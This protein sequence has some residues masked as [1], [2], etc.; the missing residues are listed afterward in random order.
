MVDSIQKL[1]KDTDAAYCPSLIIIDEAHHCTAKTYKVL[2]ER[3]P[4]ATFLGMT[5]TPC[6]L[7]KEGFYGLFDRLL[8]SWSVSRFIKEGWLSLFEYVVTK[9]DSDM[10]HR[11]RSL[12]KRG[13]DGD[14][15]TKELVS[16]MDNRASIEQLYSSYRQYAAGK[17]GIVYA[18]SQ[19]HARHITEYFS[20]QGVSIACLDATTPEKERGRIVDSFRNGEIDVL[21]SVD[22]VSEGFDVPHTDFI[23]LARPTLSLSKY[24]QQVGRGLR[25]HE[26]KAKTIILD[27][28]GHYYL[29]GLP[30]QDRDWQRMF[31]NGQEVVNVSTSFATTEVSFPVFSSKDKNHDAGH[32]NDMVIVMS[33]GC[34]EVMLERETNPIEVVKDENGYCCI[35]NHRTG[36]SIVTQ[37]VEI[38]EF[39][40]GYAIAKISQTGSLSVIDETGHIAWKHEGI[41]N[42]LPNRLVLFDDYYLSG[43]TDAYY[44]LTTGWTYDC[45]PEFFNIGFAAF[46]G[47]DNGYTLRAKQRFEIRVEKEDV[48]F[49]GDIVRCRDQRSGCDVII[50]RKY[51][52]QVFYLVG[53]TQAKHKVLFKPGYETYVNDTVGTVR[54]HEQIFL[55][56]NGVLHDAPKD[57]LVPYIPKI[58]NLYKLLLEQ[59]PETNVNNGHIKVL[60]YSFYD[61]K[62]DKY[63]VKC[64][65]KI[66]IAPQYK[67]I[68]GVSDRYF[69]VKNYSSPRS[70]LIDVENKIIL[71]P[72]RYDLLK[73]CDDRVVSCSYS[74]AGKKGETQ[75]ISIRS[76]VV[77]QDYPM[78]FE[79]V[80][81]T[82]VRQKD[83]FCYLDIN[84]FDGVRFS[85]D[86]FCIDRNGM[87]IA[88]GRK[89]T[90]DVTIYIYE[91]LPDSLFVY[92]GEDEKH[93]I[94]LKQYNTNNYFIYEDGRL[95]KKTVE[96]YD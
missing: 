7:K 15:Q 74:W 47:M 26:G 62:T 35:I 65:G 45:L 37:Y 50:H 53:Y 72:D 81:N 33:D 58:R 73:I 76:G 96:L 32:D 11:V 4:E 23:M 1:S 39:S 13:V 84:G 91:E 51:P 83:G 5:A 59:N 14:Y 95:T 30:H 21:A 60:Y 69:I 16:V 82:F 52:S 54:I 78:F 41:K 42:L 46:V 63:G 24:L 22:V 86:T 12:T 36:E 75:Y 57:V 6:R 94:I 48:R 44:D 92:A 29:F 67:E 56:K 20:E 64:N 28:V 93:T 19:V 77:Y 87:F 10:M 66:V 40:D 18:I 38:S 80:H 90:L 71:K 61:S 68:T 25:P 34:L 49:F 55:L 88:H 70:F 9:A 27:N 79:Y 31:F 17:T 3:F 2:W 89:D 8:T 85:E 43:R